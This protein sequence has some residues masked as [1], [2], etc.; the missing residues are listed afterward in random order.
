MARHGNVAGTFVIINS[1]K[2]ITE[3]VDLS[4]SRGFYKCFNAIMYN[5]VSSVKWVW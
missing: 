4:E 1:S 2:H 3:K 5:L